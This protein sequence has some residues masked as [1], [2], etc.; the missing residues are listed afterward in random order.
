MIT[1]CETRALRVGATVAMAGQSVDDSG[2]RDFEI[3]AWTGPY[4]QF[5]AFDVEFEDWRSED[6]FRTVST[7]LTPTSARSMAI[8]LLRA[9]DEAEGLDDE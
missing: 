9:A 7:N 2:R 4:A 8:A 6:G 3:T 1:P 5:V